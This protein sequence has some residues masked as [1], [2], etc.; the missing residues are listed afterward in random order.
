MYPTASRAVTPRRGANAATSSTRPASSIASKRRSTQLAEGVARIETH[1]DERHPGLVATDPFRRRN[2]STLGRGVAGEAKDLDG[3]H[4][5]ARVR[6]V[7]HVSG[8]RVRSKQLP[9]QEWRLDSLQVP[10]EPVVGGGKLERVQERTEVETGTAGDDRRPVIGRQPVQDLDTGLL[11]LGH[12]ERRLGFDEV[13]EVMR[14]PG[15]DRRGRLGRPDVH[16]P[17]HLHRVH[18]HDLAADPFRHHNRRVRLPGRRRP[19]DGDDPQ[20]ALPMRW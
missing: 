20:V 15:P 7:D 3:S 16:S 11:E 9:D 6:Q 13:D 17:V 18:R 19:D 1:R 10:T 4:H 5:P 12:R 2:G 14:D 8:V